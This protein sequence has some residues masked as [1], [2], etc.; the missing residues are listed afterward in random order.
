MLLN[1]CE[2]L[3]ILFQSLA[4]VAPPLLKMSVDYFYIVYR[5]SPIWALRNNFYVICISKL[6]MKYRTEIHNNEM[7]KECVFNP[8]LKMLDI[9]LIGN[10][11][12]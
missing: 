2:C 5:F 10:A 1:S 3:K 6:L 8:I 11:Q 7:N 12:S 9:S 4:E